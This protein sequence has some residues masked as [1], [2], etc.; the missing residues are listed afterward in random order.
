VTD[1]DRPNAVF[2]HCDRFE[3]NAYPDSN[4]F[5]TDRAEMTRKI[6]LSMGLLTGEQVMAPVAATREQLEAYH[7]PHYLDVLIAA[8]K[9]D[10]G[11]EGLRMGLGTGDCPVF[12]GLYEYAA[13]AAGATLTAA[14][15]ILGGRARVAFNP[16]GGYHHAGR[17]YASGFCYVNDVVLG[18]QALAA[19]GRRVLFLDVDVHH[20][21]GV[22]NAFYDRADVCTVSL[23]ETGRRLFPG[24][25]FPD[26]LGSGEGRGYSVNVPLP[27]GTYDAAYLKA[28]RTVAIPVIRAY[29]PDVIVMELGMD[30]L[31]GD[32]LA[33]LALTNNAYAEVTA[34]VLS[35]GKPIVAVGG[36]GYNP[37]NTAR[38]WSL[39]WSVLSGRAVAD[40]AAVGLGGVMLASTDW[41]G[42]LRDAE[43]I[44]DA[45][46]R[47]EVDR[48]LDVV[49]ED[50][51]E[52]IFGLHGIKRKDG[53][54]P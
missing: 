22:Q 40:D 26:E 13:L 32:P 21:D 4:P 6:L 46:V 43:R 3:R 9:G 52:R 37:E 30:A 8:A 36:G 38:A 17:D 49:I 51:T 33:E 12:A 29:D 27:P 16:S 34:E 54:G 15:A 50:V 45:D 25:G 19:A 1:E 28:F 2:I 53:D 41:Q 42:G 24:T 35:F 48:A 10:M 44:P 18:C 31:A 11:I 39:C 5:R 20:G 23:H 7:D 47:R 14:E